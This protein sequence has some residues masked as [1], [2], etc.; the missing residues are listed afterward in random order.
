MHQSARRGKGGNG[1]GCKGGEWWATLNPT[2][3]FSTLHGLPLR[4]CFNGLFGFLLFTAFHGLTLQNIAK[5]R[6]KGG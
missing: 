4:I 6:L 2:P 5:G 3:Y 1:G